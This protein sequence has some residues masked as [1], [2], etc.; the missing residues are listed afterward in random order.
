MADLK[1]FR[2]ARNGQQVTLMQRD[3]TTHN[4]IFFQR[5]NADNFV[6]ALTRNVKTA[7]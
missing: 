1:S 7:R 6:A 4:A 3:G 5:F 2:I